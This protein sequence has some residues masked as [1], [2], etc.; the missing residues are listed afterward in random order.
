MI[1]TAESHDPTLLARLHAMAFDA[2]WDTDAMA[3]LIA[4]RGVV[5]V[6]GGDHDGPQGVILVRATA[7]EAEILTLGVASGARRR[8]LARALVCAGGRKVQDLGA[9]Q[10][11]LEVG[12]D[13]APACALYAG[14]GF[15]QVG[16][17]P[18]YYAHAGRAAED[19]LILRAALPL[20]AG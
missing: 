3:S 18:G 5:A 9:D 10:M 4:Q 15:A 19:A 12:V 20:S 13:N 17:R 2:P 6:V 1:R 11:F 14:L 7:G 16:R 8:G